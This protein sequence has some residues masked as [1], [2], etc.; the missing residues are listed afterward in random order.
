[1]IYFSVSDLY[2]HIVKGCD[3]MREVVEKEEVEAE[4]E[5]KEELEQ[6]QLKHPTLLNPITITIN[7]HSTIQLT[8]YHLNKQN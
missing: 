2:Q 7:H 5:E 1:M 4:V 8:H 3:S 6:T